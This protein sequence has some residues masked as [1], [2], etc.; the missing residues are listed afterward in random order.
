[1]SGGVTKPSSA[2]LGEEN[3]VVQGKRIKVGDTLPSV[4]L[5]GRLRIKPGDDITN[6]FVWKDVT[7]E[8]LFKG[9]WIVL[10]SIPGGKT[11]SFWTTIS[12]PSSVLLSQHSLQ[13]VRATI[14]LGSLHTTVIFEP[15]E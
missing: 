14:Y 4:I 9:K 5:K 2:Q 13:S 1:M 11:V 15:W 10:F 7:T 8:D 6:C 3:E 12:K